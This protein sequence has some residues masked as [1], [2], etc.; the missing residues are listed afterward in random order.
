MHNILISVGA[1]LVGSHLVRLF[2]NKYLAYHIINTDVLTY[3]GNLE[4]KVDGSRILRRLS[5]IL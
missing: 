3:A 1:G 5:R 2:V 4:Q